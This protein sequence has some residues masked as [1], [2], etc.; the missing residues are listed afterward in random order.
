MYFSCF[1]EQFQLNNSWLAV[2]H[3]YLIAQY[4]GIQLIA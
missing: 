3:V 4:L 1:N 2:D